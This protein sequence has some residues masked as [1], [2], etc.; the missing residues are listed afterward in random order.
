MKVG[1]FFQ[2]DTTIKFIE[3]VFFTDLISKHS[4]AMIRQI[5]WDYYNGS[6]LIQSMPEDR[7]WG[8]AACVGDWVPPLTP[9]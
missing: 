5:I 7:F 1:D 4:R 2:D 3:I 8:Q 6:L 9:G